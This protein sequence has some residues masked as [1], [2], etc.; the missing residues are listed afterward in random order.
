MIA[1]R[2]LTA[3]PSALPTDKNR[4]ALNLTAV[5]RAV[6]ATTATNMD[7]RY[8]LTLASRPGKKDR[9]NVSEVLTS[10]HLHHRRGPLPDLVDP[11]RGMVVRAMCIEGLTVP[12][13]SAAAKQSGGYA[14]LLQT[15]ELGSRGVELT[16]GERLALATAA[17]GS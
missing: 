13:I 3:V 9:T 6:N 2:W 4:L 17:M 7:F 1:S 11:R 16:R 14:A 15:L 5:A 10:R 8:L 12:R